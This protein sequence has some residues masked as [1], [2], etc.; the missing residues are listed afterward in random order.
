MSETA[1]RPVSFEA[2]RA[3][4]G[5]IV[6]NDALYPDVAASLFPDDFLLDSNR[7]LFRRM[8]EMSKAGMAIDFTTLVVELRRNG[9]LERIGDV[10]YV[11]ELTDGMPKLA[12]VDHYAAMVK[13][14]SSGRALAKI[15]N[16]IEKRALDHE[17]PKV[18]AEQAQ[19]MLRNL[20]VVRKSEALQFSE[21]FKRNFESM[22]E[23]TQ[24]GKQIQGLQT[25]FPSFDAM[26]F[27]LQRSDLIVLA[28]RP[29]VGKTSLA[30]NIAANI[31]TQQGKTALV[32]SLE[33]SAKGLVL[34]LLCSDAQ[35]N[36]HAL[37]SG[38]TNSDHR[39]RLAH[40]WSTLCVAPLF[41]DDG[42]NHTAMQI[43]STSRRLRD[44][45][46][47]DLIVVD[48][49]QLMNGPKRE[50]RTQEISAISRGLKEAAKELDVPLIAVSQLSRASDDRDGCPRLSD[51]RESGQI[52]QDADVVAFLWRERAKASGAHHSRG[53]EEEAVTVNTDI[54]ETNL[55]IEKQRNGPTGN[56]KLM[57][58]RAYCRFYEKS[59]E[60]ES[61][62]NLF[63]A[64]A[65]A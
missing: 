59:T 64:P 24:R 11:L 58:N 34:R 29:S 49:L 39:R 42:A 3:V 20:D 38:F 4:L 36:S 19:E 2:E 21:I 44:K 60:V 12:N 16:V 32:F 54:I 61:D 28:A 14:H 53:G 45:Q 41:I 40:A 18:I 47:L 30:M 33:M 26:T 27:G 37:A 22:D 5:S 57:F 17:E 55:T 6:L 43:F 8:G 46:G 56:I 10:A 23:L 52:E 65:R 7:I 13:T 35:V 48:Y 51:L 50:N 62:E 1:E 9:E 25:G 63:T 15:G 31:S